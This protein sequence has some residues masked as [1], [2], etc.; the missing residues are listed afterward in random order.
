MGGYL[1]FRKGGDKKLYCSVNKL[2]S[3]SKSED[4]NTFN[5]HRTPGC[6][7]VNQVQY[8]SA[9]AV[10]HRINQSRHNKKLFIIII[11][12]ESSA[13][14]VEKKSS[15]NVAALISKAS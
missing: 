2:K 3:L 4:C 7:I 14:E 1:N 5:K 11:A 15:E 9:W 10:S 13:K 12:V 6:P 8:I